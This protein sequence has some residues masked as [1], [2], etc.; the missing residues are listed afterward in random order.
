MK[1]IVAWQVMKLRNFFKPKGTFLCSKGAA[2]GPFHEPVESSLQLHTVFSLLPL[3][4]K[5]KS[6]LML[7]PC[8]MCVCV[9]VGVY[10][11]FAPSTFE[12][13]NQSL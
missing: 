5:N 13:L 11:G 7:S 8:C 1:L 12:W 4:R 2:I 10:L 9:Y 3:F 6:R